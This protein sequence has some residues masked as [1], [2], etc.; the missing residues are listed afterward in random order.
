[1]IRRL[2]SMLASA[3]LA[4]PMLP[5][6]VVGALAAYRI[7][8]PPRRPAGGTGP[9][10]KGVRVRATCVHASRDGIHLATWV[11]PGPGPDTVIISHGVG[12]SKSAVRGHIR[13]L[14]DAGHNVVA[15]DM[16][17]HGE[18]QRDRAWWRMADRFVSDLG[19]VVRFVRA[20]PELGSGAVGLLA[21]SFSVWT[22]IAVTGDPSMGVSA[23]VCDSGPATDFATLIRRFYDLRRSSM[24]PVLRE[25]PMYGM[26]RL[27]CQVFC[28]NMLGVRDWPPDLRTA[29]TPVLFIGGGADAIVPPEDSV[30]YWRRFRQSIWLVA[31]APHMMAFR[32]ERDEYVRRVTTFFREAFEAAR[33]RAQAAGRA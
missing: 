22:A 31:D 25:H 5:A 4:V 16:R 15:Y 2:P 33:P 1:M 28:R 24:H 3:L 19:D 32:V 20:D 23:L 6:L 13:M 8:H 10:M 11:V 17:N 7:Y 27:A 9:A 12:L 29:P 18:S 14:R 30:S 21:F 26:S